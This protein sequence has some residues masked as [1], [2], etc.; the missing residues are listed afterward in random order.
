M[1][2]DEQIFDKYTL[3]TPHSDFWSSG[4]WELYDKV[5]DAMMHNNVFVIVNMS[6]IERINSLGIGVLVACLKS[7]RDKGGDLKI[8]GPNPQ[9]IS[10][11]QIVNLYTLMNI[12][13][14]VDEA[15]ASIPAA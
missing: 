10:V 14:T 15:V 5:K 6:Q 11:L 3:L 8:V 7:L 12:Y 2:I 4:G 13:A 9:V 1:T